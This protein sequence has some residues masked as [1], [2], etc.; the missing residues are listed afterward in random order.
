MIVASISVD[1][2]SL[3]VEIQT[4][5]DP[6]PDLLDEVVTRCKRLFLETQAALP[7]LP[8][9]TDQPDGEGSDDATT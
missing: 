1:E 7:E 5:C 4:D 6:H 9:R 2:G 3:R 8:D